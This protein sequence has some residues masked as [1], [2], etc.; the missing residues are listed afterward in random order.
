MQGK[1]ASQRIMRIMREKNPDFIINVY[2]YFPFKSFITRAKFSGI[3]QLSDFLK[4]G[5]ALFGTPD[6]HVPADNRVLGIPPEVGTRADDPADREPGIACDEAGE[7]RVIYP[8]F[9]HP[10]LQMHPAPGGNLLTAMSKTK[11]TMASGR[12]VRPLCEND[13][14]SSCR[15]MVALSLGASMIPSGIHSILKQSEKNPHGGFDKND[16]QIIVGNV[17]GMH[18][19]CF[20]NIII[21]FIELNLSGK[22]TSYT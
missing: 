20:G 7:L 21:G 2:F 10:V 9:V 8:N 18:E 12:T 15:A 19:C 6:K 11:R 16:S 3:W 1:T 22:R 17:H 5:V 4:S 14:F 13:Y